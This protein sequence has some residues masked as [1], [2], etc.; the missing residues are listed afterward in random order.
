MYI[1]YL[2]VY[3][4]ENEWKG[5][6]KKFGNTFTVRALLLNGDF[7]WNLSFTVMRKIAKW[8]R[9]HFWETFTVKER[10][11]DKFLKRLINVEWSV[12]QG[13]T[14]LKKV[15]PKPFLKDIYGKSID[16]YKC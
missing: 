12:I 14:V 13:L 2:G 15:S 3:C 10:D 5:S 11:D 4:T 6:L 9:S 1:L 8:I 16:D 7:N